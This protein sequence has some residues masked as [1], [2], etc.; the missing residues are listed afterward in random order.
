MANIASVAYVIEGPALNLQRIQEAINKAIEDEE[1]KYE[2]YKTCRYLGFTA[3]ELAGYRLGGD[4][5]DEPELEN[6][7]LR[8]W[9]EERWGLQD[10]A[11]IFGKKFPDIEVYWV[12]EEPGLE[13]FRTNDKE[14]KYFSDRYL[15]DTCIDGIYN[16]EYFKTEQ[17]AYKW[18]DKLTHGR[19]KSQEDVETFNGDYEDSDAA[20]ENWIYIHEFKI[21]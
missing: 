6:G 3:E 10:F 16:L 1:P 2:E 20:D 15:I 21:G 12:V 8:F 13:I 9:S 14:G 19:V 5:K 7:V 17:A 11:E 18:L 4:I